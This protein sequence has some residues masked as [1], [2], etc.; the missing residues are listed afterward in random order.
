M[1]SAAHAFILEGPI[2]RALWRLAGPV[3]AA[4][5]LHTAFV[6]VDTAWVGPLGAWATAALVTSMFVLW[7]AIALGNLVVTGIGAHVSRAI[8][9]GDRARAAHVAAQAAW[10]CVM[11]GVP[12]AVVG[13]LGARP[14][15]R[16]LVDDPRVAEAGTSYLRLMALGLPV[17]FLSLAGAAVMRSC[18]N[19]RTP[20][21]VMGGALAGNALLAPLLIYGVGPLP[22]L[23]VAGS[24]VATLVAMLG[25]VVAYA[26][27]ARARHPDLPLD[28]SALRRP[29]WATLG[30][31]VKVGAPYCVVGVI[32]SLVYLWYAHL[33]SAAGAAAIAVVG[34]G[35]RL[36]SITYL[37]ADGFGVASCTFVGQNLGARNPG[38][39][40]RGAWAAVG[41]MGVI[42]TAVTLGFL[43]A[44]ELLLSLFTRD[45]EALAVG[46][47]YLRVLAICQVATGVEGA[48]GG[49]FAGAGQT[50]PPMVV[51]VLFAVGRVPLAAWA[52]H[53]LDLGVL[54]IAW[55]MTVTCIL[56]A[57]ILLLL[58]RRNRWQ[59][60]AL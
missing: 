50:V 6:M 8:G 45:A 5:A 1:S 44:P 59:Q 34:I 2:G 23:G 48:I 9:A 40:A 24:A 49:A 7:S 17:L 15:F 51:H 52:V 60:A 55:T 47:T 39:A 20:L 42:G 12:V 32:F 18:G 38:R 26:A 22:A 46:A 4:E 16:V 37:T 30:A 29:D 57:A 13:F 14:L 33:A 19:T 21:R 25:G 54:G 11:L 56:R 41:F 53:A 3:I 43:A 36:E 35:N 28:A 31:L 58:F 10:L 27:L